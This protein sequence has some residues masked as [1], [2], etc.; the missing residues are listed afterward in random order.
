MSGPATFDLH[1]GRRKTDVS[2]RS[3]PAHP[4]MWRIH[5]GDH[6]SDMVNLARA[7][8]GAMCWLAQ[9]RGRGLGSEE[10]ARWHRRETPAE[11]RH[12]EFQRA[13][14]QSVQEAQPA[15]ADSRTVVAGTT[16]EAA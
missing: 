8:D 1:I 14:G 4:G 3:D 10:V 7:K 9:S 5:Q 16:R 13:A 15:A 11:P 2:V 12:S 6:D